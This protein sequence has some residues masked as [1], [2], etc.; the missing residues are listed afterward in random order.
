[1]AGKLTGYEIDVYREADEHDEDVDIE[2][3]Q[4]RL[5]AGYWTSLNA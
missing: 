4:M 5:I 3:F 1:L 2:E